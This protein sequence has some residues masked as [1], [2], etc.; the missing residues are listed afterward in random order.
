MV[1]RYVIYSFTPGDNCSVELAYIAAVCLFEM[2][3]D[4]TLFDIPGGI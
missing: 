3:A 1:R 2:R 4:G